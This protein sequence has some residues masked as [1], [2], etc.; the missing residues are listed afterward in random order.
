MYVISGIEVG[1]VWESK[2]IFIIIHSPLTI[3]EK[4]TK[5]RTFKLVSKHPERI[6]KKS[7]WSCVAGYFLENICL[8][9][10]FH[11]VPSFPNLDSF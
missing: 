3:I 10:V 6:A 2:I 8:T 4:L 1:Y 11:F 9:V 7:K 5:R